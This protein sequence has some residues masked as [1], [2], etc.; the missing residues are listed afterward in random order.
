[1][2]AKLIP[3]PVGSTNMY[4]VIFYQVY[5]PPWLAILLFLCGILVMLYLS[6]RLPEHLYQGIQKYVVIGLIKNQSSNPN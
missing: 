6:A 1:M 3:F 4:G 2:Y 5:L